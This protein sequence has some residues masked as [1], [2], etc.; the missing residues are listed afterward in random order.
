M[1]GLK[2]NILRWP[3]EVGMDMRVGTLPAMAAKKLV[4]RQNPYS[5]LDKP[6]FPWS[7]TN[8]QIM[9]RTAPG[10]MFSRTQLVPE[11]NTLHPRVSSGRQDTLML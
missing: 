5:Q 3:G 10:M 11:N 9:A 8:L 2:N 4:P 7:L 6:G 1:V